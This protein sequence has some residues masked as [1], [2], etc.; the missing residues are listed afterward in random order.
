MEKRS[1]GRPPYTNR[2]HVELRKYWARSKGQA[3]YRGEDWQLS[4]EEFYDLWTENDAWLHKG[5]HSDQ[6]CLSRL[7]VEGPWSVANT[8]I[9]TRHESKSRHAK[10]SWLRR[11]G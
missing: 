1:R 11:Y 4:W 3:R 7:D 2:A 5:P 9:M 10:N 8:Q 6:L